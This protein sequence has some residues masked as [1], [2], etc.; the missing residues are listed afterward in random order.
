MERSSA[1]TQE[2]TTSGP[3]DPQ[4]HAAGKW[5]KP[6]EAQGKQPPVAAPCGGDSQ[7]NALPSLAAPAQRLL[8]YPVKL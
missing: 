1:F 2:S 3:R 8:L 5:E 7:W 4:K 6:E